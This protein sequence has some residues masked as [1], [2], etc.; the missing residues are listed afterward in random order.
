[1]CVWLCM[2]LGVRVKIQNHMGLLPMGAKLP[3]SCSIN[4]YHGKAAVS[5]EVSLKGYAL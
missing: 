4:H 2:H 5:M 3:L 1:M